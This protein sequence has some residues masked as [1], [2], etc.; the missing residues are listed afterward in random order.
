MNFAG[1]FLSSSGVLTVPWWTA[2]ET[3]AWIV[4]LASLLFFRAFRERYLL[5]WAA[6]WFAYGAFLWATSAANHASESHA[7][8]KSIAVFAQVDFIFAMGLFAAAA[9]ISV[10]ARRALTAF[11]AS[12][13]VVMVSA[14][15]QA[16]YFPDATMLGTVLD[17][18]CRLLAA[19][20]V[21][22]FLRYRY[23][24]NGLGSLLLGAGLL[25]LNLPW[26]AASQLA[27]EGYL[28]AE[29]LFGSSMLLLALDDS[30]IQMRRLAVLNELAGAIAR[31]QNRAPII[32]AALEKLRAVTGAKAVWFDFMESD[33]IIPT[34]HAGLSPEILRALGQVP[35]NEVKARVLAEN[36]PV[37]MK[38]R[39]IPS[40]EREKLV[41]RAFHHVLLLPVHGKNS[42]VGMLS[43]GCSA[44][45]HTR[46]ELSFLETAAQALGITLENLRLREQVLR[47]QRQWVNTFDSIP[48]LILAHD[49]DFRILKTNHAML[50]RLEKAPDEVLGNLCKDI[51]PQEHTWRGL[52]VLR[53][54]IGADR[55]VG[56]V[57][58]RPVDGID[59]VLC[60]AR[61]PK[62]GHHPRSARHHC[63]SE[64]GRKVPDVIR[65]GAG[66]GI[67]SDTGW[68]F[69]R[70]Q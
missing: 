33:R 36:R 68:R 9:L 45:R 11:A 5:I 37:I 10:N 53:T 43:L 55:R 69:A 70:L 17:G 22:E 12:V 13:W 54:R 30:R 52:P 51:L 64:G 6:G 46:E 65:T 21:I 26:P 4:V 50:Q 23:R 25:T 35:I 24:R 7:V 20:A 56:S 67:R 44:G 66:R 59:I 42:V 31:S 3:V 34:Q 57:F 60:R 29:V 8:F 1:A 61:R 32:Q 18:A 16:L 15:I 27:G 63:P 41:R 38:V 14:G 2:R 39:E 28:L 40:L 58:R 62:E 19:A 48:D 49:A 47:S